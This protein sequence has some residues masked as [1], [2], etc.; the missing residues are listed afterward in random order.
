MKK[1]NEIQGRVLN[2]EACKFNSGKTAIRAL[3]WFP[4]KPNKNDLASFSRI[5]NNVKRIKGNEI[6]DERTTENLALTPT[7]MQTQTQTQ[8]Q[9]QMQ[10]Q[11]LMQT[12]TQREM[13]TQTQTQTQT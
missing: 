5:N 8:T 9:T 1:N 3:T 6:Q 12:E 2:L 13:Q 11:T 10:T 4:A 7:H